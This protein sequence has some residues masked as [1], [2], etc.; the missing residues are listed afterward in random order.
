MNDLNAPTPL[1]TAATASCSP[2]YL[3][4][5]RQSAAQPYLPS[6]WWRFRVWGGSDVPRWW[7]RWPNSR[8]QFD[9]FPFRQRITDTIYP[10]SQYDLAARVS[11]IVWRIFQEFG[12][13]LMLGI[14]CTI[15][16]TP[17]I[18]RSSWDVMCGDMASGGVPF[19]SSS[20]RKLYHK[21][22][23]SLG[24]SFSGSLFLRYFPNSNNSMINYL[25][26][27]LDFFTNNIGLVMVLFW[28][29]Y[30]FVLRHGHILISLEAPLDLL[31]TLICIN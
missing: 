11:P 5:Q 17:F 23:P 29:F 24:P 7:R 6:G 20:K 15:T 12:I 28:R 16:F 18:L 26:L 3:T 4:E 22:R 21:Y 19:T 9:A 14:S 2:K 13:M 31:V 1:P 25:Q 27:G 10:H 30:S 8:E